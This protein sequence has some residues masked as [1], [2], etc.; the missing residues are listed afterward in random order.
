MLDAVSVPYTRALSPLGSRPFAVVG[1]KSRLPYPSP[2]PLRYTEC[3]HCDQVQVGHC[4]AGEGQRQKKKRTELRQ[5]AFVQAPN[6]TS[7]VAQEVAKI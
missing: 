7:L 2:N 3:R 1:M 6:T 5:R 4:R